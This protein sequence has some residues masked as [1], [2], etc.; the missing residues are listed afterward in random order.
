MKRREIAAQVRRHRRV[1][2]DRAVP[3]HAGEALL[4]RDVRPARLLGRRPP[5]AR[6]PARRRGARGRRRRVPAALP[7]ADGGPRRLRPH[8]DLRLAQHADDHAALRPRDAARGRRGRRRRRRARTSSRAYLQSVHGTGSSAAWPRPGRRRPATTSSGC[9]RLRVVDEDGETSSAVDVRRPVGIEIG[10]TVLRDGEPVLPKI[11]VRDRQGDVAFNADGHESA[12]GRADA[13]GRLR[14]DRVDPRQPPQRGARSASTSAMRLDRGAAS[15]TRT[16]A[17]ATPSPSTSRTPA[18]ATRRAAASRASGRASCGRCSSGRSRSGRP[19]VFVLYRDS[20]LRRAALDA[21]VGLRQ[22]GTRSSAPTSSRRAGSP[23]GTASSLRS[24]PAPRHRRLDR[25]LRAAVRA[26]RRLRAATSPRCWRR[27]AR[28]TRRTSSSRRSTRSGSR[29]CCSRRRGS[30]RPPLVYV[31]HRPAAPARAAPERGRARALYERAFRRTAAIVAYG[32][33]E[34]EELRAWLPGHDVRFVPFGVDTG[35]VRAART[36]S[37]TSTSS[38]SARIPSGTTGS[39]RA[40]RRRCPS[41]SFSVRRLGRPGAER[42]SAGEHAPS[43][44]SSRSP[45][46]GSG[47]RGRASSRSPSGTTSTRARPRRCSRRWRRRSRSSSR[48]RPR[49]PRATGSRTA[50]TS[51]SCRPATRPR[52]RAALRELLADEDGA[53]ALGRRARETVERE[54]GW[55]RYVDRIADVLRDAAS[56]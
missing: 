28:R 5:R 23:S 54:L 50:S 44:R 34:A 18:R 30:L 6:D 29:R 9:A 8:G 21:E 56:R 11:K 51:G 40:S 16:P 31:E 49:S 47:S 39:W 53:A 26:G 13:A 37:P 2:R 41:V 3:R 33:A 10:F 55:E 1:L 36:S 46:R 19:A 15:S 24:R 38:R 45:R 20:P 48:A 22:S 52:S 14:G 32:H 7:R 4:E 27:G 12:L 17:S 35:G 25:V 42:S 43:R